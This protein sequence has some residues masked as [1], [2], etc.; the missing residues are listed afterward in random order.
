[1]FRLVYMDVD[2]WRS[3]VKRIINRTPRN[4]GQ[5]CSAASVVVGG[6]AVV[7]EAVILA[8]MVVVVGVGVIMVKGLLLKFARGH[9][10]MHVSIVMESCIASAMAF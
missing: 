5:R 9:D 2:Y 1:M 4:F 8:I 6:I 10:I 3:I 7:T